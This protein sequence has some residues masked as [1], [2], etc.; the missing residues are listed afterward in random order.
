MCGLHW[1]ML[2]LLYLRKILA[3]EIKE[4]VYSNVCCL[5]SVHRYTMHALWS[6]SNLNVEFN[7]LDM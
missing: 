6:V 3:N 4:H 2:F 7:S 5:S 1:L